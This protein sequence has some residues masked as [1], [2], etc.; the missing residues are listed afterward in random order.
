MSLRRAYLAIAVLAFVRAA[1]ALAGDPAPPAA[2]A[3]AAKIDG[4]DEA[5]WRKKAGDYREKLSKAEQH[6]AECEKKAEANRLDSGLKPLD[7]CASQTWM[8][9]RAEDHQADFES[10]AREKRVP[11]AW[12]H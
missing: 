3:P 4:H 9:E 2:P 7:A 1:P 5:W 12:I 10:D 11:P 6:V 8:V